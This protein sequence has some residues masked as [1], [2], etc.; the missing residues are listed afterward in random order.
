MHGFISF[1]II[2]TDICLE[3]QIKTH[4][5]LFSGYPGVVLRSL[6][7]WLPFPPKTVMSIVSV[8]K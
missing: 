6:V 7:S 4:Q 5:H 1:A 2:S 8:S 3:K